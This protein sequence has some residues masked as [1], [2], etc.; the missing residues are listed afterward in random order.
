MGGQASRL[1]HNHQVIVGVEHNQRDLG[2]GKRHDL[3][4]DG[5][6]D[7]HH[8]TLAQVQPLLAGP[9]GHQH[10]LLG[11]GTPSSGGTGHH[12][13]P[14]QERIQAQPYVCRAHNK[15]QGCQDYRFVAAGLVDADAGRVQVQ[16][17]QPERHE[18]VE[19]ARKLAD[20]PGAQQQFVRDD[21]RF[22]GCLFQRGNQCL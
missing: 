9:P 18:G 17:P 19:P 6:H 2:R 7:F 1:V 10:D 8:L 3:V 21:L 16:R 4:W 14:Q 20:Q 12:L 22:R 13:L 5:R 11:D 15:T